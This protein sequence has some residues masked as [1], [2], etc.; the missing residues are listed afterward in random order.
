MDGDS[1]SRERHDFAKKSML[2][3]LMSLWKEILA[4]NLSRD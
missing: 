1:I 4:L 3:A 2:Q